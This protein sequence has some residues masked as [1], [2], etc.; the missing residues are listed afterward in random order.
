M[1]NELDRETTVYKYI[2]LH[3]LLDILNDREFTLRRTCDWRKDGDVYENFLLRLFANSSISE[4]FIYGQCW[5]LKKESDAMWRIYSTR[6]NDSMKSMG[7]LDNVAV[8]VQTTVNKLTN[9]LQNSSDLRFI[10][11]K[12]AVGKVRYMKTNAINRWAKEN[13]NWS[14]ETL[15]HSF[16]FKR[17]PFSHEKEV[18]IIVER[19]CQKEILDTLKIE[20]EPELL[21]EKYV[22]DP[23]LSDS[24]CDIVKAKLTSMGIEKS[25]IKKSN[26]YTFKHV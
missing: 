14:N 8:K 25:K 15:I 1:L 16:F 11:K 20:I 7:E 23:R 3:Y 4:Q 26:L 22:L 10:C 6:P 12:C 5:T 9:M 17:I 13:S 24:Q 18:R 19:D 2:P 21:F